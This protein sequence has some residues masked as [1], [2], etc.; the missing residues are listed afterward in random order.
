MTSGVR[1]PGPYQRAVR[2]GFGRD[3]NPLR[4][5]SDR[6]QAWSGL[7]AVLLFLMVLPI[8]LF[9]SRQTWQHFSAVAEHEQ[10]TRHLIS[11]TV[12][13]SDPEARIAR[14]HLATLSWTYPDQVEHVGHIAVT[15]ST[16]TGDLVPVWVND[17]GQMTRAPL[18]RL[19]VWLDTLGIGFGLSGGALL[20]G[21]AWYRGSRFCLDRWRQRE[22]DAEWRRFNGFTESRSEGFP[23]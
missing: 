17:E 10:A 23:P 3:P 13:G 5:R 1:G 9:S 4:R 14:N 16:L 7:A 12:V 8:A 22:L 20:V 11:A 18:T 6:L 2:P 19:N 15:Q 21:L